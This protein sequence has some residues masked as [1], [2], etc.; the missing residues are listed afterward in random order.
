MEVAKFLGE[1]FGVVYEETLGSTEL[2][3]GLLGMP[4]HLGETNEEF[5]VVPPG[6]EIVMDL[7]MRGGEPAPQPL[8]RTE[9]TA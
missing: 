5:V 7:F 1:R 4:E 3:E 6:G 2:I 9:K 8:G